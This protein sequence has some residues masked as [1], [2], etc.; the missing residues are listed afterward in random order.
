M[1]TTS[2]AGVCEFAGLAPGNYSFSARKRDRAS[3]E[4]ALLPVG[5]GA[6]QEVELEL[7]EGTLVFVRLRD[8]KHEPVTGKVFLHDS[9]GRE[10][11]SMMSL[12]SLL[13]GGEER[14]FDLHE[15]VLGP[16]APGKYR[17]TAESGSLKASR[18][19]VLTGRTERK[20]TL[21]LR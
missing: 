14:L 4:S 20:I 9:E 10:L 3:L 21:R 18:P 15:L 11:Q 6:P 2:S 17:V 12:E 1:L 16:L 13:G 19:L 7:L 8:P 5:L